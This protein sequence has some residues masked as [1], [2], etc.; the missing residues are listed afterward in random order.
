M[1]EGHFRPDTGAEEFADD[2]LGVMLGYHFC[3]RLLRDPAATERARRGYRRLL[4]EIAT[5]PATDLPAGRRGAAGNTATEDTHG[6]AVS[7]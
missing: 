7:A 3:A 2:L 1:D 5:M 4:A 6:T